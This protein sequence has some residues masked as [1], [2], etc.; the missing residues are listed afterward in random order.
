MD[1]CLEPNVTPRTHG[2]TPVWGFGTVLAVGFQSEHVKPGVRVYGYFAPTRYLLVPVLP[3][4][5]NRYSFYVDRPYFP[6]GALSCKGNFCECSLIY[7][8]ADRRPYNQITIC[9]NDPLYTP[10]STGEDLT[11]L[12]RPLFW[13]A[14]WCEDWLDT[15]FSY[16]DTDKLLISSASSKTAFCLAYLA[17]KRRR[18]T[19]AGKLEI[20]GLTSR[21]NQ[22]FTQGL[23]LYD[24]VLTYESFLSSPSFQGKNALTQGQRWIYVDVAGNSDLNQ[25]IKSHF[26]S[27]YTGHVVLHVELGMTNLAPGSGRSGAPGAP[28]REPVV[29][30]R[31]GTIPSSLQS[32]VVFESVST[33]KLHPAK[34]PFFMPT[35]LE[36]RRKQMSV[37]EMLSK[38][39][40]AWEAV[41]HEAPDWVPIQRVYGA[42]KVKEAYEQVVKYGIGPETGLVWSLWDGKNDDVLGRKAML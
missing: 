19:G 37:R 20:I 29:D 28:K 31:W 3:K 22:R 4:D 7:S 18:E 10:T 35:W 6:E 39:A 26:A 23:G 2:L 42:E 27:P 32:P 16:Q 15:V 41:M 12:Y 25:Q 24:T 34:T 21:P 30:T 38:Q 33:S 1:Q 40:A 11:M 14:F 17:R 9:S 8:S 5:V 36:T 13:T